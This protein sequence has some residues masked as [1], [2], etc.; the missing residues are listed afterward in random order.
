MTADI[1]MTLIVLV[2][3]IILFVFEW[4]RVDV[5][6]I[7]MMVLLPILG[8]I[9]PKQAFMGL[10]SNAVV[11]IIAVIIIG[12]GLD[13]TG[14]MNKVANPI[15][16]LAGRSERRLMALISATVGIISG[17]IQNIG[18]AA[19]FLPATQRISK[20]LEI[21]TDNSFISIQSELEVKQITT[22]LNDS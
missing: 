18:A 14:V 15:V 22:R 4:V 2:F 3:V 13:K 10:S 12:A 1:V 17:L 16:K 20:R 21:H 11:S 6:G 19:L 5:V 9:S 7:I 8:L